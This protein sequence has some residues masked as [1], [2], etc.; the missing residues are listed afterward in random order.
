MDLND[1]WNHHDPMKRI[2]HGG[3]YNPEQWLHDPATLAK[4]L[5]L[6][7][8]AGITAV[9]LGIFSWSTLEPEDGRYEFGWLDHL[10]D[11][12]HHAGVGVFLATAT[13]A[14]PQW[15]NFAHPEVKRTKRDGHRE[16]SRMR[17]NHCW[18]SSILR[19]KQASLIDRL[20]ARYA[21][22]PAL[23]AWH[24]DNEYGGDADAA[25]CHC[26]GCITGFQTWLRERYGTIE[27]L[28]I[29]WWTRFWSHDYQ[30][31]EQIVP[32]EY[33]AVE[34]L[35]LNWRRYH[36]TQIVNTYRFQVTRIRAHSMAPC[37]TNLHAL[38]PTDL[39]VRPLARELDI[40]GYDSYPSIIGDPVHDDHELLMAA[41]TYDLMRSLGNGNPFWLI[42]SCPG[43]PQY[44]T[45][46][47]KRP[48]VHRALSLQA[49]AHGADSVMYFQWRSGRGGMEKLHGAVIEQGDPTNSRTF[50]EV[51]QLGSELAAMEGIAGTRRPA[52]VA[53]I[54]DPEARDAGL[55]QSGPGG[56]TDHLHHV[57]AW[58][59]PL[60]KRGVPIDIVAPDDDLSAY[61]VILVP[62][63]ILATQTL[64]DT[65]AASTGTI[66]VGPGSGM[67][68]A[69]L[70]CWPGGKPGPLSD[71][72]G[73]RVRESDVPPANQR[74][75]LT[76]VAGSPLP[77]GAHGRW[78]MEVID[79]IDATVA[80]TYA[81]EFYA[82]SPALT[83][84]GRA[85]FLATSLEGDALSGLIST[86][87]QRALVHMPLALDAP[88]GVTV[89]TRGESTFVCSVRESATTV[90]FTS[91]YVMTLAACATEILPEGLQL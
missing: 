73:I 14:T 62:Y 23:M 2:L 57:L 9:S 86:L 34:A 16:V 4:D 46:R 50:A 60:W 48:G 12:L 43:Q 11:G 17:H 90:T 5:V 83:H 39:F 55:I 37:F 29:A 75:A 41:F 31:W 42:E 74:V 3:D 76:P 13:A 68:D 72:L 85:W 53:I 64:A 10:M 18:T 88:D 65:L 38:P 27:K 91:G 1:S 61:K 71:L 19:A 66:L 44:R 25:R 70:S 7:R 87:A 80:A 63:A 81:G 78:L 82:G 28:N 58:Y 54:Y 45:M 22:H 40:I 33:D 69:D 36:A 89:V 32:N 51:A 8:K 6:M 20:A 59:R 77:S 47:L 26:A 79:C 84:R 49:V 67:L 30:S 35:E 24:I 52:E 21:Q 56:Q 15:L